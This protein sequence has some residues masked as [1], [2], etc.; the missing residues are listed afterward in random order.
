MREFFSISINYVYIESTDS[1]N[2][3][4]VPVLASLL[5]WFTPSVQWYTEVCWSSSL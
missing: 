1:I 2:F 5:Q 3:H 4:V